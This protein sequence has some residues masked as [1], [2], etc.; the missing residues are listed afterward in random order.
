MVPQG[1]DRSPDRRAFIEAAAAVSGIGALSGCLGSLTGGSKTLQVNS[2]A[3]EG[4]V[5][6]DVGEWIG[7][8]VEEETGGEVTVEAFRNS[9]LGGQI[10]SIENVSSGSLDMYV[11]PY[12]LTGTQ[13]EPAQVFDAPY[14]YDPNNPYEDIYEKTDPQENDVAKQVIEDLVEETNIR[15]L[16]AV[17]QG[18]RRCTLNVENG[19]DP[20]VNPSQ[21]SNYKMR[22]VP[23]AMYEQALKGLG[24]ETTNIDASEISQALAT[25]SVQGQENPYNIIRSF[26]IWEN[27]NTILETDHMHVPLAIIMNEGV[28][29]DL[30]DEQQ[31]IFYDAVREVQPKATE[32]LNAN[33]EDHRQ[34]MRDKGLEIVPPEDLEMDKFRSRTRQRIRDQFPDLIGTIEGLHDEGYPA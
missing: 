14:L 12:A 34:F 11:I 16:G 1:T 8:I 31:Q 23:I 6:G 13:Y 5:H 15:S 29:Q 18:T 4:S 28:F 32:T 3:A 17:V 9:E 7:D 10:E 33:L 27:Q 26:G 20:P 22:A 19:D 21:L 30:T 2:P 24:A 25:G